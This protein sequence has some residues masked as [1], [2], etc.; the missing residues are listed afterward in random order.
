MDKLD[1]GFLIWSCQAGGKQQDHREG[2]CSRLVTWDIEDVR[3][4]RNED[5]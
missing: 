2:S 1:I 5:K 3:T 4:G